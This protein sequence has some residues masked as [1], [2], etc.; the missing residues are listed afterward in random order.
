VEKERDKVK[1]EHTSCATTIQTLEKEKQ[2][3]QKQL[4]EF[5][6]LLGITSQEQGQTTNPMV[7]QVQQA[8]DLPPK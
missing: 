7:A 5:N 4:N 8:S 1:A 3:L 6:A 2:A